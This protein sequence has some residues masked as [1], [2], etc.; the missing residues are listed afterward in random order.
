MTKTLHI[1]K[2]LGATMLTFSASLM[3][4][5]QSDAAMGILSFLPAAKPYLLGCAIAGAAIHGLG[6]AVQSVSALLAGPADV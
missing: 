1:L 3:G 6:T 5:A 4:I 2:A